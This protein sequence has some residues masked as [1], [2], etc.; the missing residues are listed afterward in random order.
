MLLEILEA[1]HCEEDMH[2][3]TPN[4]EDIDQLHKTLFYWLVY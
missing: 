1:I 4:Y 3:P 2:F